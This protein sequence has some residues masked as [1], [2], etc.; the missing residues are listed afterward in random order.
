MPSLAIEW[1]A[2]HAADTHNFKIYWKQNGRLRTYLSPNEF[3]ISFFVKSGMHSKPAFFTSS[4]IHEIYFQHSRQR[5]MM[6][7]RGIEH[8]SSSRSSGC[9]VSSRKPPHAPPSLLG[10]KCL[11]VSSP[12][13]VANVLGS[14]QLSMPLALL[15]DS[16]GSWP[17]GSASLGLAC[18]AHDPGA[19]GDWVFCVWAWPLAL[20]PPPGRFKQQD[21]RKPRGVM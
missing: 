14:I 1:A 9:N 15:I 6:L 5:I 18:E 11:F 19:I 7:R 3:H 4:C 17:L 10:L 13:R 8:I 16:L 12:L 2:P 21:Q 20:A